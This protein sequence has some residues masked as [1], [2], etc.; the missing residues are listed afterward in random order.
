MLVSVNWLKDFIDPGLSLDE[1]C[2]ELTMAGLEVEGL[3]VVESDKSGEDAVIEINVTPNRPDWLSVFG[4]ARELAAILKNKPL[5]TP[6][7]DIRESD[8]PNEVIVEVAAS[9]LC[10]RYAARVIRGVRVAPSPDW[11]ASRLKTLGIRPINNV[12]DITNYVLMELG[13]PLH[14]FDLSKISEGRILIDVARE[15]EKF[16]TL[17]G[18]EQCLSA[19]MLTIRD[20]AGPV[21]LAGIMGG[22][23][24]EVREDTT[25]VFLESAYFDPVSVRKTSK[26][27][28]LRS[29]SSYRFER[30]TD[31]EGLITALDRA[32]SLIVQEAGGEICSG[33]IDIYPQKYTPPKIRLTTK[34]TNRV[35]G[36]NLSTTEIEAIIKRL[37]FEVYIDKEALIVTPPTYRRDIIR[38]ID[39]IED[40]ARLYGY[41]NIPVKLP[42]AII[43][44]GGINK[45]RNLI[46]TIKALLRKA[47]FSEAINYS[48][49][50][51][52]HLDALG[53]DEKDKRRTAVINLLNPL[54]AEESVLRTTLIPALLENLSRNL[55]RGSSG[56]RLFELSKIFIHNQGS[57][58]QQLV[59]ERLHLAAILSPE[60]AKTFYQ[61]QAAGFY[62]LKGVLEAVFHDLKITDTAFAASDS[63][64]FLQPGQAAEIIISG[65]TIGFIGRIAPGTLESFGIHAE[66]YIFE[67]DADRLLESINN[68]E[69]RFKWLL[70]FPHV[71]RDMALLASVDLPSE[72]IIKA[73]KDFSSELITH[74]S[75]FDMYQGKG[76]PEGRKSLAYSVRYQSAD[77]TLTVAE[78]DSIHL[79]LIDH[80]TNSLGVELRS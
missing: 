53:I 18:T 19:E 74:V 16:T 76:I 38:D 36:L 13:H 4:V 2:H 24:S 17:D 42:E 67:L 69:V 61:P 70:R 41:N 55:N 71:D 56:L 73:V 51:P 62:E 79:A 66:T 49:M 15:G 32:A 48:F 80:V 45:R 11:L 65:K 64:K 1:L 39:L 9:A 37:R 34:K 47:G 40:V 10:P 58:E 20:A 30:G 60:T 27:L 8:K 26:N 59:K 21:A 5:T 68:E 46:Y 31:I 52:I 54:R 7:V 33:K 77:R 44:S 43:S 57:Q 35:L 78:V 23:D 75:I 3:E 28:G 12:V 14:A 22:L 50:N 29:E 6:E 25:D 72:K 63:E